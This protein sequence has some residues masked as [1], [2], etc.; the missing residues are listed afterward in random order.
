MA[1][2][3]C[4]M[5]NGK[6]EY[7]PLSMSEGPWPIQ[8]S[9]CK[10]KG[11]LKD[12]LILIGFGDRMG[13]GKDFCA[14]YLVENHGFVKLAFAGP[15]KEAARQIFSFDDEQLYGDYNSRK[16]QPDPYWKVTP[17]EALQWIGTELFRRRFGDL[18]VEA[19]YWTPEE[20]QDIWV[21][22]LERKIQRYREQGL[23]RF[24]ISDARFVNEV[25][26]VQRLGGKA[27]KLI[28]PGVSDD[29]VGAA[30]ASEMSL[31]TFKDWDAEILNDGPEVFKHLDALVK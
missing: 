29:N 21:R 26:C 16:V 4:P 11:V 14:D 20:A 22:A 18:A 30:H 24:A 8:C 3:V 19:G 9:K 12:P 2:Q 5:C 27:V 1:D 17:R 10:G 13:V 6:G 25:R 15:L 28:R 31:R 23:H 7:K